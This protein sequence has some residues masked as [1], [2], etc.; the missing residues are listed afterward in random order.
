ML[1]VDEFNA[2]ARCCEKLSLTKSK[3]EK[4]DILGVYLSELTDVSL[5]IAVPAI[6]REDLSTG[7]DIVS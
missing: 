6:I 5:P 4:I 2:F 1:M 3:N 7:F